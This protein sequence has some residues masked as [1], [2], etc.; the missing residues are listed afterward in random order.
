MVE[1]GSRIIASLLA[2][3]LVDYVVVT[4]APRL[5]RGLNVLP[6]TSDGL[7][8]PSPTLHNVVY[9]RA[10]EDLILWGRVPTTSL[11]ATGAEVPSHKQPET[12]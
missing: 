10:G 12:V 5:A 2:L 3:G 8:G 4:I 7:T 6:P 11:P 9:T 1:G